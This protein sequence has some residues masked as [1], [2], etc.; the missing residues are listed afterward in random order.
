MAA[1]QESHPWQTATPS[2]FL[3]H[4]APLCSG[5]R[6]LSVWGQDWITTGL[7][8]WWKP[9][10]CFA[11]VNKH[12]VR[13]RRVAPGERSSTRGRGLLRVQGGL[14]LLSAWASIAGEDPVLGTA[15]SD[16]WKGEAKSSKGRTSGASSLQGPCQVRF[17]AKTSVSYRETQR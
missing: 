14:Q 6:W 13:F 5:G 7:Q 17:A 16:P 12:V 9:H 10:S 11:A 8:E 3:T 4:G 2:A 15:P 1:T